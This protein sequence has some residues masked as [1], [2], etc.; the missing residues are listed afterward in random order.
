MRK[1]AALM[2]TFVMIF[3]FT[4]CGHENARDLE[5]EREAQQDALSPDG[6]VV[7]DSGENLPTA[8][9]ADAELWIAIDETGTRYV[10]NAYGN[11]AEGYEL[12]EAGN[13]CKNGKCVITAE[14][15]EEFRF[16][17]DLSFAKS[18]Y[19]ATLTAKEESVDGNA[20]RTRVNQYPVS[21][22][23]TLKLD[24]GNATNDVIVI[25]SGD[26]GVASVQANANKNILAEG[27]FEL[28]NGE[29]AI[30]PE[31]GENSVNVIITAY[32]AGQTTI[33]AKALAGDAETEVTLTVSEGKVDFAEVTPTPD[34][35]VD[36]TSDVT[37]H[38]VH[39]YTATV[40]E[41]TPW[42]EG[43]TEYRCDC[44]F[45]YKDNFTAPLPAPETEET[46]HVH[47]YITSVVAPTET[48]EGYTLHSCECG[49][50]YCDS[51]VPA[52]GK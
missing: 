39:D 28:K 10:V 40:V 16:L 14:N 35:W 21:C 7:S 6:T 11:Y 27:E 23:M 31:K 47:N 15:A 18:A 17:S 36:A 20:D 37:A 41:A 8:T 29:I 25:G 5:A 46:P 22:V 9:S 33:Y 24:G 50:S 3:T 45:S 52:L 42:S 32:S 1:I 19:T 30:K 38:H 51:W 4:A 13:I 2:L 44:G 26:Q 12:D 49:D 43:Y 34:E 48:E